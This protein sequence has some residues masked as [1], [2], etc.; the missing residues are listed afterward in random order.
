MEMNGFTGKKHSFERADTFSWLR[1]ALKQQRIFDV[2]FV[3]PPTFS[4]SKAMRGT[5]DVQRDHAKL[6]ALTAGVLA[7]G[8]TIVFS[9]N[10][11]SF[12]LD[13]PALARAGLAVQNITAQTIPPDFERNP[14]IHHCYL[15]RKI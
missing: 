4:N 11:R 8:G 6:L 7:P 13:E 3:D 10:L 1:C 5:W 15:L 14:K 2:I 9:C 12:K